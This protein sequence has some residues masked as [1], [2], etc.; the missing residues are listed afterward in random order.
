MKPINCSVLLCIIY[1]FSTPLLANESGVGD[2]FLKIKPGIQDLCS[3]V[4]LKGKSV[5]VDAKG[6]V[7]IGLD[8]ILKEIAKLGLDTDVEARFKEYSGLNQKDL[9]DQLKTE[10]ECTKFLLETLVKARQAD[11]EAKANQT[12]ILQQYSLQLK[13]DKYK[14]MRGWDYGDIRPDLYACLIDRKQ[15]KSFCSNEDTVVRNDCMNTWICSVTIHAPDIAEAGQLF[16]K[17]YDADKLD[18][19]D[20]IGEGLCDLEKECRLTPF[21]RGRNSGSVVIQRAGG[22]RR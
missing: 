7:A 17:V 12:P 13:A 22:E 10:S 1:L 18:A 9:P 16:V 19:H 15:R 20:V 3:K 6:A 5:E 21:K 11:N 4:E 14:T 8:G 2:F